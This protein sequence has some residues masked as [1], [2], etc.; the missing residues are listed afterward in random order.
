M[1]REM[2]EAVE[3]AKSWWEPGYE[4]AIQKRIGHDTLVYSIRNNDYPLNIDTEKYTLV[5]HVDKNGF[6]KQLGCMINDVNVEI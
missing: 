6:S 3:C 1:N 2:K 4:I 5:L